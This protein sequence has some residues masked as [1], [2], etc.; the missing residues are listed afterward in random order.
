MPSSSSAGARVVVVVVEAGALVVVGVDAEVVVGETR[1]L[2]E[3][4]RSAGTLAQLEASNKTT[5]PRIE[6][7]RDHLLTIRPSLADLFE[8]RWDQYDQPMG[9]SKKPGVSLLLVGVVLF[10]LVRPVVGSVWVIGGLL[11]PIAFI[12]GLLGIVGGGYLLAR[13]TLGTGS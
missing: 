4:T 1:T 13:S 8:P 11:S 6:L 7:R 12:V 3:S 2:E 9:I 5:P 10:F